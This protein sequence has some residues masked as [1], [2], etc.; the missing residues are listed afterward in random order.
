MAK[1][2][3]TL[4]F[5][6]R[7]DFSPGGEYGDMSIKIGSYI[8]PRLFVGVKRNFSSNVNG[9]EIE[10]SISPHVKLQAEIGDDQA[11]H[12]QLKWKKDY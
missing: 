11:K 6:D 10:A 3:D 7:V 8:L 2:K 9:L 4:G 12:I 1:I 5:I